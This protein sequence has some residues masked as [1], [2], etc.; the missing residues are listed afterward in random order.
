MAVRVQGRRWPASEDVLE[1]DAANPGDFQFRSMDYEPTD[2]PCGG[3]DRLGR[4]AYRCPR[5]GNPCGDI[6]VGKN[7]KP[8]MGCPTW[9]WDGNLD[10]P[11]L[12]PSI[13]CKACWHGYL[14]AG[15]FEEC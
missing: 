1:A 10:A 4:L 6:I 9:E 8:N 2:T 12:T 7:H 13:N 5:T 11:T 14:K 3:E 15:V